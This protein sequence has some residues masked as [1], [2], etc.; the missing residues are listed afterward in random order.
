VNQKVIDRIQRFRTL[1]V[2][3]KAGRATRHY[4]VLKSDGL[5]DLVF[6]SVRGGQPNARQQYPNPAYQAGSQGAWN[7][8]G[9]LAGAQAVFRYVVTHGGDRSAGPTVA[10]AAFPIHDYGRSLR[11]GLAGVAT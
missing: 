8:L 9:K 4:Q 10:H 7:P 6:Q 11:T 5:D 2:D 1:T 3:V